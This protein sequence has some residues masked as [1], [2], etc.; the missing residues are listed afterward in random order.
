MTAKSHRP[1][2]RSEPAVKQIV[3][4]SANGRLINGSNH[5]I[6]LALVTLGVSIFILFCPFNGGKPYHVFNYG[7]EK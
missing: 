3:L 1:L 4:M 5:A 2:T 6:T 7:F